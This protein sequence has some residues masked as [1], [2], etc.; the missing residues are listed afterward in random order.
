MQI[1]M[2]RWLLE[3]P[4]TMRKAALMDDVSC[5]NSAMASL[6]EHY[7]NRSADER[8]TIFLSL[9]RT[10]LEDLDKDSHRKVEAFLLHVGLLQPQRV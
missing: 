6:Q 2:Q 4:A 5:A 3:F 1:Q 9:A 7:R 8:Q 10:I